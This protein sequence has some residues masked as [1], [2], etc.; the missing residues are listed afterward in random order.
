M[1]S[2]MPVPSTHANTTI[3]IHTKPTSVKPHAQVPELRRLL[4]APHHLGHAHLHEPPTL[5]PLQ[6]PQQLVVA[7]LLLL[8]AAIIGIPAPTD[9]DRLLVLR[10]RLGQ[11]RGEP[12]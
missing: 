8:I 6:L 4:R 7:V 12:A 10:L 5:L 3:H 9:L 1:G 11:G 2:L